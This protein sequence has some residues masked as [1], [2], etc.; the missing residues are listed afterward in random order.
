MH[1]K[2]C[3]ITYRNRNEIQ[4]ITQ[5][6]T[7][8]YNEKTA[9]LYTDVSLMTANQEIGK[10]TAEFFKNMSIA[11][12]EGNY[13]NLLV[14]PHSLKRKVLELIDE[15]IKKGEKGRII[16]KMNSVTDVDFIQKI[17]EASCAEFIFMIM[18]PFSPFLI[19][20]SINSKTFR[21][22]L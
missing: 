12:L 16:M 20:S 2:I 15:E 6:G 21:F 7:G 17:R 1:S 9:E 10:D 22:K 13:S 3:Q 4:Y 14:S 5:I 19:S 18:R 11:N 8:N